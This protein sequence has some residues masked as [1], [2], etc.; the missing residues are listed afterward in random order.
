MMDVTVKDS[1]QVTSIK[2]SKGGEMAIDAKSLPHLV[3][4]LTNI[5]PDTVLAVLREY[6]SNA[7]DSHIEAGQTRPIE[8]RLPTLNAPQLEIEDWGTGM[9]ESVLL[10]IFKIYG[11][12]TKRKSNDFLGNFGLGSKSALNISDIFTL[13]TRKDGIEYQVV[14]AKNDRGIGDLQI[15]KSLPTSESN[16]TLVRIPV[17]TD[18]ID[19]YAKRSNELFSLWK[20]G[21]VLVN[22]VAPMTLAEMGYSPLGDRGYFKPSPRYLPGMSGVKVNMGGIMYR[23]DG[24]ESKPF[25]SVGINFAHNYVVVNIPVGDLELPPSR[26]SLVAST[27]NIR[28]VKEALFEAYKS[29]KENAQS[30]IDGIENPRDAARAIVH[31]SNI[32]SQLTQELTYRGEKVIPFKL[33]ENDVVTF[34]GRRHKSFLDN[35]SLARLGYTKEGDAS[36]NDRIIVILPTENATAN[37]IKSNLK[38][39]H[40]LVDQNIAH[41]KIVLETIP[42]DVANN[43]FFKDAIAQEMMEIIDGDDFMAKVKAC[44]KKIRDEERAALNANKVP[45]SRT[46]TTCYETARYTVAEG[47]TEGE[48]VIESLSVDEIAALKKTGSGRVFVKSYDESLDRRGKGRRLREVFGQ[49]AKKNDL[50]VLIQVKRSSDYLFSRLKKRGVK[51]S[52]LDI[53]LKKAID[54]SKINA[55]DFTFEEAYFERGISRW[56]IR[57]YDMNLVKELAKLVKS[58]DLKVA[59][60]TIANHDYLESKF[61]NPVEHDYNSFF[62]RSYDGSFYQGKLDRIDKMDTVSRKLNEDYEVVLQMLMRDAQKFTS[63]L[64][65]ENHLK[66]T[67]MMADVIHEKVSSQP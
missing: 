66:I 1:R 5:Y 63:A 10:N 32:S 31:Y 65:K 12:S 57:N 58:D 48:W 7:L 67:A 17:R 6:S 54:S 49:L 39:Y 52:S 14:I 23:L 4:A 59:L 18:M 53:F 13:I 42:D 19:T 37:R 60:N 36:A 11:A 8:V 38:A 22:G 21:S 61:V 29:V 46:T 35:I 24:M 40:D 16:G 45:K 20:S 44:Q 50:L 30:T 25:D 56:M 55:D 62:N 27:D 47:D 26:E 9:D 64:G 28:V 34:R 43:V 51:T 2:P 3:K 33:R 15:V 41:R